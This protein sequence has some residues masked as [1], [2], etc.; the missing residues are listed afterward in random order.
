MT[1]VF[2]Q[3]LIPKIIARI[4]LSGIQFQY[5]QVEAFR[6]LLHLREQ[7]VKDLEKAEK[8]S[9]RWHSPSSLGSRAPLC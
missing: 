6:A 4:Y 9:D 7:L 5:A 3:Q 8:F 2:F 1:V